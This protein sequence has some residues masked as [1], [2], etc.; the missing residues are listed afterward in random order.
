MT[1]I[2]FDQYPSGH[3]GG[4][5]RHHACLWTEDENDENRLRWWRYYTKNHDTHIS[6]MAMVWIERIELRGIPTA[7]DDWQQSI[8]SPSFGRR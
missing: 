3:R 1:A 8:P 7:W 4:K 5:E 2:H 6:D